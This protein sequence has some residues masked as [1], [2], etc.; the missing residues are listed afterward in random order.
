MT[1]RQLPTAGRVEWLHSKGEV[2]IHRIGKP[3]PEHR[4][5]KGPRKDFLDEYEIRDHQTRKILWYAHFHYPTLDSPRPAFT[6]AHLKTVEQRGS[7]GAYEKH[8]SL[9]ALQSI[10][11]YRAEINHRLADALFFL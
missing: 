9:N 7:G 6:A 5:L 8:G 10:A 2:T 4:R 11:I 3:L 1:K